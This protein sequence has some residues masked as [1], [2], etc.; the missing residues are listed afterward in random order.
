MNRRLDELLVRRGQLIERIAG[1][2]AALER[3]LL[4]VRMTVHKAD[5]ILDRVRSAVGY[6]REHPALTAIGVVGLVALKGQ[7]VFGWAKRAFALWQLWRGVKYKLVELG[8]R[9]HR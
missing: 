8:L 3:D 7:R 1:Q 9:V 2:R 5:V 4:P 6:L